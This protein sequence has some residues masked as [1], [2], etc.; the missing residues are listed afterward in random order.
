MVD[1]VWSEICQQVR[2][3]RRGNG[4]VDVLPEVRVVIVQL[5]AVDQLVGRQFRRVPRQLDRVRR[6]RLALEVRRLLRN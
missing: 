6:P 3:S 2:V 5:V 1:G 4:H